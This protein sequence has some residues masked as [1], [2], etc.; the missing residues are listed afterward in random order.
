MTSWLRLHGLVLGDVERAVLD[1]LWERGALK[2]GDVHAHV[3]E[4]R[5]ISVNTVSSALKRLV[6]KGLLSREKVS[7]AYV[8]RPRVTREEFQRA[9]LNELIDQFGEGDGSAFLAAFVDLAGERGD[10]TLER[11]E[12][13]IARRRGDLT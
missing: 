10:E 8:Y 9:I 13:I 4:P 11:L 5:G 3:G 1:T 12:Q 2:P 7:H 6:D